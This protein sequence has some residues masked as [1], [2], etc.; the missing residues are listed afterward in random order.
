[1]K[2]TPVESSNI[3]SIGYS[4]KTLEVEFNSGS[5]Y[6]YEDVPISL[7]VNFMQAKSHGKFFHNNVKGKYAYERVL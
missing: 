2:R 1:M 3:S 6:Q 5:V 7:W 4:N